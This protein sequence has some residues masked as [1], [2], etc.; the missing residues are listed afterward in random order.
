MINTFLISLLYWLLDATTCSL[1]V[2]AFLPFIRR[3]L[4]TH[5]FKTIINWHFNHQE[6]RM[7]GR[8][9]SVQSGNCRNQPQPPLNYTQKHFLGLQVRWWVVATAAIVQEQPVGERA[10]EWVSE[11]LSVSLK[12]GTFAASICEPFFQPNNYVFLV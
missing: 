8:E 5:N 12:R 7:E 3:V 1:G 6:R 11:C 10:S 4:Q 9:L 2:V